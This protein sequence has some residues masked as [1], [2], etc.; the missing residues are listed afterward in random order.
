LFRGTQSSRPTT[1][2]REYDADNNIW[3]L[4]DGVSFMLRIVV[5]EKGR[6]KR[7]SQQELMGVL[8]RKGRVLLR[9]MR[10]YVQKIHVGSNNE[11]A[12][13]RSR[14]TW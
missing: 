5:A 12:L 14:E 7:S 8:R 11:H 10:Y 9:T 6:L 4:Q 2:R 13:L 1:Q 3:G